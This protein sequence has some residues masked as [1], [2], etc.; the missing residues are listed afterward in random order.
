MIHPPYVYT[1]RYEDMTDVNRAAC[2]PSLHN[3]IR[4]FSLSLRPLYPEG[5][6][7]LC[8]FVRRIVCPRGRYGN[9]RKEE[10]CEQYDTLTFSDFL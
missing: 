6:S 10:S 4:A 2:I 3:L 5:K 9:K 1:A 8:P 7:N